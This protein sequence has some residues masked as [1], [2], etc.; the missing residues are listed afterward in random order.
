MDNKQQRYKTITVTTVKTIL[1]NKITKEEKTFQVQKTNIE[2]HDFFKSTN[3]TTSDS[4]IPDTKSKNKNDNRL[5]KN[6]FKKRTNEDVIEI[7]DNE[8]PNKE[9]NIRKKIKK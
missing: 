8:S 5:E 6:C 2:Y 9:T 1:F 7:L 3:D 4:N